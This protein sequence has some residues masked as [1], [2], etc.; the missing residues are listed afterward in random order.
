MVPVEF[1]EQTA[2]AHD[3]DPVGEVGHLGED[4]AR[5]EDAHAVLGHERPQQLT[6]ICSRWTGSLGEALYSLWVTPVPAVMRCTSPAVIWAS[7]PVLSRWA[8]LPS[9]T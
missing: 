5:H 9:S 4:V 2:L 1:L 7:V 6:Q 8:K 3:A